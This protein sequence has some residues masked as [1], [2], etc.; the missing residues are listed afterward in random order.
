[1]WEMFATIYNGDEAIE[2]VYPEKYED[3]GFAVNE[4]NYGDGE[5]FSQDLTIDI[6]NGRFGDNAHLDAI[7]LRRV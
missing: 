1:M 4:M 7:E 2:V 3:E 5:L 6:K